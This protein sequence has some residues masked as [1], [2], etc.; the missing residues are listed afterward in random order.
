MLPFRIRP[1]HRERTGSFLIRVAEANHCLPWSFLRLLGDIPGGQR[2]QLTPQSCVSLN[3]P[4]LTRLAAYLGRPIDELTRALPW[5]LAADRRTEPTVHIHRLGRAFLRSC[6]QCEMRSGGTPL[7]PSTHPLELTCQRHNQ[8]LITDEDITLD[9]APEIIPAV[10]R[11]R[12][13]RQRLGDDITHDH[14]R[15]VHNY[16]TNDWRGTRWHRFLAQRWTD[17][18]HRMHPAAHPHDEFVRSH[19]H[20]WSMLPETVTIVGLLARSRSPL[21]TAG[22]ISQALGLDHYWST[23]DRSTP[24]LGTGSP[25]Y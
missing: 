5:I 7:M 11:L 6:P 25:R 13:L 9:R 24:T 19:T 12:R 15:C 23:N 4:A 21:L 8:W 14:Y 16:L 2:S 17:R 20:H 10:K 22:D 1:H 18:Q 3:R